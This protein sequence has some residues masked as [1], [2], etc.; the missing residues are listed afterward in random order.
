MVKRKRLAELGQMLTG[1]AGTLTRYWSAGV[2]TI[3][4]GTGSDT[5]DLTELGC[6]VGRGRD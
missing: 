6:S 4:T 2:D 3:T 5:V 1:G